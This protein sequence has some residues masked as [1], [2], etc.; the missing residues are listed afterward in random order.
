MRMHIRGGGLHKYEACRKACL[1]SSLNPTALL[2]AAAVV[3]DR[4]HV[5]D[6]RDADAE[7]GERTHRRLAARAGA[8]DLDV[9]VLDALLHGGAAGL[10]GR[11][12][13]GERRRLARALETLAARGGPGQGV[14]LAV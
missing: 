10:L 5:A 13:R 2:R 14:A 7:C 9:E 6:R 1:V 4:R 3:R 12:L 11:D 8:L